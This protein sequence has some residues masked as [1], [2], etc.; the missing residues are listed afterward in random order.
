MGT[1]S[2]SIA[3]LSKAA[4]LAALYNA[5]K[6]QGMGFMHYDPKPMT[7]AEAEQVLQRLTYIDYLKGRLMKIDLSTDEIDP[8][9]YDRDN[10][11]GTVATIIEELRK[12][13]ETNSITAQA[14][15]QVGRNTA[16]KNVMAHIHEE[17]TIQKENGVPTLKLGLSDVA[18][19][20]IPK[21]E[22]YADED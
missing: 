21:V 3:G 10:G 8:R 12:T 1:Q 6:P 15:H 16:A 20:L 17:S 11:Q 22:R 13:N 5:S 14:T 7:I 9:L 18:D 2:V 19:R 4:V